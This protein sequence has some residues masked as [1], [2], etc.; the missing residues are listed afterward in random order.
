MMRIVIKDKV[1]PKLDNIK[2]KDY[3]HKEWVKETA[4]Q[5]Q[6]TKEAAPKNKMR[7]ARSIYGRTFK[8]PLRAIIGIPA[9]IAESG[10]DYSKF[11]TG[12][13]IKITQE[14]PYF[15]V[16][17]TVV[18]GRDAQA[19]SGAPIRWSS[20]AGWWEFS[21]ERAKKGF[22][23]ATRRGRNAYVKAMNS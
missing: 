12:M 20:S 23:N 17:Q 7:L 1:S 5:K 15:A 10:F 6:L 14:N 21:V 11:V 2:L 16:G 18:Y 3:I 8:E 22:T 19:P 9:L 4:K 13:P